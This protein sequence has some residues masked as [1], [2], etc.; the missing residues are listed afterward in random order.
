MTG[1]LFEDRG[2]TL[3]VAIEGLSLGDEAI[4]LFGQLRFENG[5]IDVF[6]RGF[7]LCATQIGSIIGV[8]GRLDSDRFVPTAGRDSPDA[9]TTSLLG[10]IVALLEG[11]AVDAVLASPERIAQHTRIFRYIVKRT[12]IGKLDNVRVRLAD[13]SEASLAD[14]RRRAKQGQRWFHRRVTIASRFIIPRPWRRV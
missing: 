14:V 4:G 11:V 3:I 8:S 10:R 1:R 2:H 7:K 13:S 9:A 6:K 12:L 5:P